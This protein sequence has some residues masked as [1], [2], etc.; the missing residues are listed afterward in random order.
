[1]YS[2]TIATSK[3]REYAGTIGSGSDHG[4]LVSTIASGKIT[5]YLHI[6]IA[7]VL[8][9]PLCR[10]WR[11]CLRYPG[12]VIGEKN[13][14]GDLEVLHLHSPAHSVDPRRRQTITLIRTTTQ[15]HLPTPPETC[16]S[17]SSAGASPPFTKNT[18]Q[19]GC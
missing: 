18:C 16:I 7:I 15:Q 4:K 11:H 12:M 6:G 19:A 8:W 3:D 1:M 13:K 14:A 2:C 10:T 17:Y 9:N 5:L